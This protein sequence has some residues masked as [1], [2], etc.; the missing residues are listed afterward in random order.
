MTIQVS[1]AEAQQEKLPLL[2]LLHG[3]PSQDG[4]SQCTNDGTVDINKKLAPK[5]S[6]GNWR[7]C[8]LI[9]GVEFIEC[10]A[11]AGIGTNL[12]TYLTTVL[13]ESNIDAASTVST[14]NGSCY[15]TPLIG[16]FLADTYWGRY[17][18]LVIF[19][20]VYA[21]GMLVLT[22]SATLP[23]L[24]HYVVYL[25]LYLV[26]LGTGGVKP[27]TWALG[28]DQF[29]STDPAEQA[30]KASFFNWFYFAMTIGSLLSSTVLAWV[31]YSIGWGVGF[32]VA[33]ALIGIALAVFVSGKRVY[34]Y[35]VMGEISPMTR[36]FQ[37]VVAALKKRHLKLPDGQNHETS[38]SIVGDGEGRMCAVTKVEELKT[39][40]RMLPI[41]ASMAFFTMVSAQMSSTF[42]EQ[43]M[44]MDNRVGSFAMP[45]ASMSSFEVVS[46]L[47][48][49]PLYDAVLVPTARRVTGNSRVI[50]Q[51]QRLGVGLV[52]SVI[53]MVYSALLE[54]MRL[55]AAPARVSIMWQA[56]SYVIFGAAEVFTNIGMMEFFYDQSPGTMQSLS[57]ALGQLAIAAGNYL[58]SGVLALV[59]SATARGGA[60]GW[61]PDDLNEG[62]LDYFF[63]VMAGFAALNL[64]L[65][66]RCSM[67]YR[68]RTSS[69]VVFSGSLAG[70]G[71]G[72]NL[73]TFLTT[74][75]HETNVDAASSVTTWFGTC[76]FT[77]LL[78]AF[79]AD[80]YW[81]RYW[82]LVIF[83]FVYTFGMLVL[84]A[85]ATVPLLL[86]HGIVYL[87][88][89]LV[90]LGTGGVMP[91]A[92]ALGADQF[93]S[94]DPSEQAA[95]ASFFNWLYFAITV[96]SVL[97]STVLVWVQDSIG[98]GVGFAAAMAVMCIAVA[99][100][101]AGRKV[102]R[103][104]PLG[105]SPIASVFHVMVAAV[106]NRR[107]KI[108]DDE[109]SIHGDGELV[110]PVVCDEGRGMCTVAQVEELKTLQRMLPVWASMVFFSM[111]S[112]QMS[113]TFVEQGMAMDNRVGSFAVPPASLSSFEVGSTLVLIPLY[114]AVLV[115]IAR[116]ATGNS[117][118]L[119][120][121]QRLGVGLALS[122]VAMTYSALLER[123]RLAAARS[124]TAPAQVNIMWQVPSY[125]IFGTAEV[126]TNIGML[127]F[128]YDQSPGTMKSLSAALG[129]LAIAAG[130][131][132]NSGVLALVSSATARGGAPGWIPDDLNEGH[133][134]YFF[135]VMAGFAAVNLLLYLRCSM[136][137]R[138]ST[139]SCQ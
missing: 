69:G 67:S 72:M 20:F 55:V 12:V 138:R 109:R 135:W 61:I 53:A 36:L 22:A 21:A 104:M 50:S 58:N 26:A 38:I 48:L 11:L 44:A 65:Y 108:P 90:A 79:L 116:R 98:W 89:Y 136:S 88:L 127:E 10:L 117:R 19:F 70:S 137:Y 54:R 131:Y 47:V 4:D 39:L 45:P 15:F 32:A 17:W 130:N 64:L 57:A 31:Q 34:R 40:V 52:L 101:I 81:G 92:S 51:L 94:A 2:P 82:T 118:G 3:T 1:L 87:G 97:S 27:C 76:F 68:R 134:D 121:L 85:S 105:E 24:H 46:T 122:V 41:W 9:L 123:T 86:H 63:W 132:L 14:W 114:D 93:D 59:S 91:C 115:P 139:S 106:R 23:S 28:A 102:Y 107:V 56:P 7:A 83:L 8:I 124:E 113:S 66:L 73:V 6:T 60:P 126:F 35:R 29:D 37:V 74:V 111:A 119:S 13:H 95:K 77:P 133:L 30:A 49:I 112:S 16:A 84:T 80:T 71:I 99:V 128:F 78:G 62:H 18:T 42:V 5:H 100:F 120:Q 75:L 129:Q 103:Y 96:G 25:G 43:G 110:V 125:A 33:T